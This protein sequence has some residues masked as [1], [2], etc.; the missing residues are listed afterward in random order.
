MFYSHYH[1]LDVYLMLTLIP[2]SPTQVD[3]ED[4]NNM[5]IKHTY[6]H[7]VYAASHFYY[8]GYGKIN[9]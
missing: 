5:Q 4:D 7:S 3:S 9:N 6:T 1:I 2:G 8:V